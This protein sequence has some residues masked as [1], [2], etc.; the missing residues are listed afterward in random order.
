M[1]GRAAPPHPG[2]YGVPPRG[3]NI[4]MKARIEMITVQ[5]MPMKMIFPHPSAIQQNKCFQITRDR[6]QTRF[7]ERVHMP[8]LLLS[9]R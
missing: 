7:A 3:M 9:A 8:S 4:L 5:K 6:G 2:I 1:R